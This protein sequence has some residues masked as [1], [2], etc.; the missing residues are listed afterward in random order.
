MFNRD[1]HPRRSKMVVYQMAM[2]LCV[3]VLSLWARLRFQ[4]CVCV[5]S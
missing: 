1:Y 3:C 5:S 4:V 2:I